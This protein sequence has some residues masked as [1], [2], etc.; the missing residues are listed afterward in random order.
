MPVLSFPVVSRNVECNRV[1]TGSGEASIKL[2]FAEGLSNVIHH[3]WTVG[4]D[5]VRIR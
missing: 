4:I 1:A 2:A 5:G 3:F